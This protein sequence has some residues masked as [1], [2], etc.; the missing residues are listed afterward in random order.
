MSPRSAAGGTPGLP[1][2]L[3]FYLRLFIIA[4][5]RPRRKRVQGKLTHPV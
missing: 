5:I 1:T 3:C 4:E 2:G